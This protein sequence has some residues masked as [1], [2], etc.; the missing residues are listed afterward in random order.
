[1]TEDHFAQLVQRAG[2]RVNGD[3]AVWGTVNSLHALARLLAVEQH[4][5]RVTPAADPLGTAPASRQ[6]HASS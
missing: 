4:H 3:G 6:H 1:M 2:L 5:A